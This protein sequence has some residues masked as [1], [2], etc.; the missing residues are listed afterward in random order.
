MKAKKINISEISKYLK[1]EKIKVSVFGE[2][3]SGK[4][5]FLNAIINEN[6]LTAAYEPTTAVPTRIRYAKTF[7]IL[8]YKLSDKTLKLYSDDKED[9]TW[10]RY[11]GRGSGT[12][13]LG[14]LEKKNKAI[15]TFLSKW[16]KEGNN[17]TEVKEVIIELPL[18]WLKS[19][20]ELIDTPGTNNEYTVHRMF[21]ESVAKETDIAIM[22]MDVRQGGGKKTELEFMNDVNRFVYES[23]VVANFMDCLDVEE[24]EDIMQYISSKS[25]PKHWENPILPEIYGISA[26]LQL[27]KLETENREELKN[28]FTSFIKN[29]KTK[30]NEKKG[31]ILL[32]RLGNPEKKIYTKAKK[33]EKS[34]LEDDLTEAIIGYEELRDILELADLDTK[35]ADDGLKR[36]FKKVIDR[37]ENIKALTLEGKSIDPKSLTKQQY[38]NK[39]K[40]ISARLNDFGEKNAGIERK[41]I[42]QTKLIGSMKEDE[43]EIKKLLS[44]AEECIKND[45]SKKS[46]NKAIRLYKSAKKIMINQGLSTM[47]AD[48]GIDHCEKIVNQ[49]SYRIKTLITDYKRLDYNIRRGQE[50]LSLDKRYKIEKK[51]HDELTTLGANNTTQYGIIGNSISALE[52]KIKIRTDFRNKINDLNKII[53]SE[54]SLISR[55]KSI[56]EKLAI[57]PRLLSHHYEINELLS[58]ADLTA[59][60]INSISKTGKRLNKANDSVIIEIEEKIAITKTDKSATNRAAIYIDLQGSLLWLEKNYGHYIQYKRFL[61]KN[62][63]ELEKQIKENNRVQSIINDNKN[64]INGIIAKINKSIQKFDYEM[65]PHSLTGINEIFKGCEKE[66]KLTTEWQSYKK[67]VESLISNIKIDLAEAIN[68]ELDKKINNIYSKDEINKVEKKLKKISAYLMQEDQVSIPLDKLLNRKKLIIKYNKN[69]REYIDEVSP[70]LRRDLCYFSE[71]N[72]NKDQLETIIKTLSNLNGND[73]ELEFL[74]KE[75]TRYIDPLNIDEKLLIINDLDNLSRI[76]IIELGTLKYKLELKKVELNKKYKSIRVRNN[77][78]HGIFNN[79]I[80]RKKVSK[81]NFGI[82]EYPP[83]HRLLEK[84]MGKVEGNKIRSIAKENLLFVIRQRNFFIALAENRI[85]SSKDYLNN[86]IDVTLSIITRKVRK[87]SFSLLLCLGIIGVVF[88]GNIDILDGYDKKLTRALQNDSPEDLIKLAELLIDYKNENDKS[89]EILRSLTNRY[90]KSLINNLK[91]ITRK[92]DIVPKIAELTIDRNE[93]SLARKLVPEIRNSGKRDDLYVKVLKKYLFYNQTSK[94]NE[95][96]QLIK[97]SLKKDTGYFSITKHRINNDYLTQAAQI[98][99]KIKNDAYRD[100]LYASLCKKWELKGDLNNSIEYLFKI[101]SKYKDKDRLSYGLG[102]KCVTNGDL[103]RAEEI[104]R[105]IN[106]QWHVNELGASIADSYINIAYGEMKRTG[107]LWQY[108]EHTDDSRKWIVKAYNI[109]N[110]ITNQSEKDR[111]RDWIESLDMQ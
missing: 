25:I 58:T 90:P 84:E 45:Q 78:A 34:N 26:K 67:G 7:N 74:N 87:I 100:E 68:T 24:R 21:T 107:F 8:V 104:F 73:L 41:I 70:F 55:G 1:T 33:L 103:T 53:T 39:L 4:T 85:L 29:L 60:E 106:N 27:T 110:E 42:K 96:I 108:R 3:S 48:E 37:L 59:K 62:I 56:K 54:F 23:V 94:A 46:I 61:S 10:R 6:I 76:K 111:L 40:K 89:R 36:T 31:S 109:I 64:Q 97:D 99:K 22:L 101:S 91:Y 50:N 57:L 66:T 71:I 51:I 44:D 83:F 15:Q 12:N 63:P 69:L 88:I 43:K 72:K 11:I 14:L 38:L 35:P 86:A 105:T 102:S 49:R 20:I 92:K 18:E 13:I 19:G 75:T 98:I 5:T 28:D 17:A 93:L 52:K 77:T 80:K 95:I 79:Y 30:I 81:S 65:I 2:F 32:K 47:T 82:I 9:G 16:T